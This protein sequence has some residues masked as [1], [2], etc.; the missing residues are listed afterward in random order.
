MPSNASQNDTPGN[1]RKDAIMAVKNS[2][3]ETSPEVQMDSTVAV[4][5][6]DTDGTSV[7][8]EIANL[9]NGRVTHF[10]SIRGNSFEDKVSVIDAMTNSVPIA[11]NLGK[12]INVKDVVIVPVALVNEE[13][14]EVADQARIVLIDADGTAY[15]AISSGL[16][17]SVQTFLQILGHPATWETPLPIKV[18]QAGT[19]NRKYFTARIA[20]A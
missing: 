19:G 3:V 8:A 13:T 18:Q 14:G 4:L 10:T 16:F 9:A 15:H 2:T 12:V 5:D 11:D 1:I 17:R 6:T 20:R 7:R